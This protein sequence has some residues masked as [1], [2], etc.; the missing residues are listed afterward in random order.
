M[1]LRDM[2]K[3]IKANIL[4]IEDE[5]EISYTIKQYLEQK[6]FTV[7][8]LS[9]GIEAVETIKKHE[10]D[11]IILDWLLPGKSGLEICADLR[12]T[13]AT[14]TIP[15]LMLSSRNEDFEKVTG[16]NIG[17]DDYIAKPFNNSE[18]VARINALL[19]RARPLFSKENLVYGDIKIDHEKYKAYKNNVELKL[20]PI[21]FQ[22]LQFF[23][24]NPEKIISKK[25]LM[26][27]IWGA[28]TFVEERTVDVHITRLRKSISRSSNTK[29]EAI[30][31]I[32][33]VGYVLNYNEI[34]DN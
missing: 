14:S 13:P 21:E 17:A 23:L 31:T 5:P 30:K 18:L 20:A 25:T 19:R 1:F 4:V 3:N 7:I 28:K 15:I 33:S 34:D 6:D 32:R 29:F 26:N 22:F 9:D 11:L 27:K 2:K 10:P 8:I 16:L 12:K 24:E